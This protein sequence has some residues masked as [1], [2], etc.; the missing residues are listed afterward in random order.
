MK[1]LLSVII[2][3]ALTSAPA[4]AAKYASIGVTEAKVRSCA[5]SKC[6]V[7]WKAWKFTPVAMTAVSK[8]K[9]WVQIKDFAGHTGWIYYTSLSKTKGVSAKSDL[10]V[11][12]TASSGG[13]VACTVEKGYAMKFLSKS[14]GWYKVS[15]WPEKTGDPVCQGWVY[16][17]NVWA[18]AVK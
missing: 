2:F 5:G 11:R 7:K 3:L 12:K 17:S 6:A 14:N 15:D 9:K 8:D 18:P 13:E 1:R 10:N 4:F 16:A